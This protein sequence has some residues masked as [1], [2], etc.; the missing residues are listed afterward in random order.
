MLR[1]GFKHSKW[2]KLCKDS[3]SRLESFMI[4]TS[5][6]VY[7][8]VGLLVAFFLASCASGPVT[9]EIDQNK[10]R[11]VPAPVEFQS[12]YEAIYRMNIAKKP[13]PLK[14]FAGNIL[15]SL[16]DQQINIT[17]ELE[18]NRKLLIKPGYSY[19][20]T[21]ESFCVHEGVEQP[22]RG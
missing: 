11:V 19:E 10:N 2:I 16:I 9:T 5:K 6:F 1:L 3:R 15:K 13:N 8:T 14:G 18:T 12:S 4:K 7:L 22:V 21:L 17:K 20:F